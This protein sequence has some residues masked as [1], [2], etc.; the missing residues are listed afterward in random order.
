MRA[1]TLTWFWGRG[2]WACPS[3]A[4]PWL[5]F[6]PHRRATGGGRH[7]RHGADLCNLVAYVAVAREEMRASSGGE[8]RHGC[9]QEKRGWSSG[10]A[11]GTIAQPGGD[12]VHI[13]PGGEGTAQYK[14]ST[15]Y[16]WGRHSANTVHIIPGGGDSILSTNTV[17]I[18]PGG[19]G[20]ASSVQTQCLLYLGERGQLSTNT[21][22]IILYN[23][24]LGCDM[25]KKPFMT[26]HYMTFS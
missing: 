16:T 6:P 26:I 19:E 20:T 22:H 1:H 25:E 14:H 5:S 23:T 2:G 3:G 4:W 11:A 24:A 18:I 8:K 13:I 10:P 17:H 7:T 15:H 9:A 12:T 21:V